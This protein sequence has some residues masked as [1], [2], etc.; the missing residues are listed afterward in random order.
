MIQTTCLL[1][2]VISSFPPDMGRTTHVHLLAWYNPSSQPCMQSNQTQ[3]LLRRW[4]LMCLA[5]TEFVP[6]FRDIYTYIADNQN[7]LRRNELLLLLYSGVLYSI[8]SQ[9]LYSKAFCHG[10]LQQDID[11]PSNIVWSASYA[12]TYCACLCIH[13]WWHGERH[14]TAYIEAKRWNSEIG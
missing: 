9:M 10:C 5:V 8:Q 6:S 4:Y 13:D 12:V 11:K 14:S 3:R 2:Q 1:W 7:M